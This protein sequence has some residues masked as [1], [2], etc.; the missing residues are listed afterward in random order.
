MSIPTAPAP[1]RLGAQQLLTLREGCHFVRS[2]VGGDCSVLQQQHFHHSFVVGRRG[3][4][5]SFATPERCIAPL[6]LC[7]IACELPYL[8]ER[9]MLTARAGSG[10]CFCLF[11]LKC[12]L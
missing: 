9:C 7:I 10:V 5:D 3:R 12:P 2:V 1:L 6:L 11:L 4:L 8:K